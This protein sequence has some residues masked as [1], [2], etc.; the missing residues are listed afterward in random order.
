MIDETAVLI[1]YLGSVSGVT[2][3]VS[4]RL[5]GPPGL[6]SGY[7]GSTKVL[8]VFCDG[9]G[10]P[11]DIPYQNLPFQVRCYGDTPNNAHDVYE[12]VHDALHDVHATKVT[13]GATQVVLAKALRVSGPVYLQELE[14]GW[15][16][17]LARYSVTMSDRVVA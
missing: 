6:P 16:F 14:V 12:A 2:T 8:V 11:T 3:Q 7:T 17:W 9:S 4:T 5:Y 15:H 1:A 13:V 10:M